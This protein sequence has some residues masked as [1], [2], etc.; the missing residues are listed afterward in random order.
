MIEK[1]TQV[2]DSI[3]EEQVIFP[4]GGVSVFRLVLCPDLKLIQFREDSGEFF[5]LIL[6]DELLAKSTIEYLEKNG[7]PEVAWNSKARHAN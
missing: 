3:I 6:E 2:S 7:V 5:D 4:A 1:Q